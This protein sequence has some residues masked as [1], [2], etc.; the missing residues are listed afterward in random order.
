MFKE[1][2]KT[3]SLGTRRVNV[4]FKLQKDNSYNYYLQGLNIH[5]NCATLNEA[6]HE[7]RECFLGLCKNFK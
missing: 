7:A 6:D 5:G 3:E 4:T 2:R 1:I